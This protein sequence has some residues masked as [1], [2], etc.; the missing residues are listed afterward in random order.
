MEDVVHPL[1]LASPIDGRKTFYL[2][3]GSARGVVGMTDEDGRKLM[4]DWI[5]YATQDRFVYRHTWQPGDVVIWNDVSTLHLA[6]DFD[7]TKYERLVYRCWM[8]PFVSA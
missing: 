6:T 4:S 2:T 1:V 3:S 7:D 8:T 5:D